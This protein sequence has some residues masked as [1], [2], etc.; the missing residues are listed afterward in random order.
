MRFTNSIT[1]DILASP[2]TV[3]AIVAS[4]AMTEISPALKTSSSQC[5]SASVVTRLPNVPMS[6]PSNGAARMMELIACNVTIR[7]SIGLGAERKPESSVNKCCGRMDPARR[8]AHMTTGVSSAD[9]DTRS[10]QA[11]RKRLT[12]TFARIAGSANRTDSA[13]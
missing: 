13:A 1:W 7:V 4:I 8:I 2:S 12:A 5:F 10:S 3:A 6:I 9:D 11:C